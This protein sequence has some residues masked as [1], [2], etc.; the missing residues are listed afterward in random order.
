MSAT[1][2]TTSADDEYAGFEGVPEEKVRDPLEGFNRAMF[3][4]ND[5]LTTVV[6]RPL[7]KGYAY[8]VPRPVRTGVS[9]FF[10][11]VRFPVRF[12]G[13]L[14]QGKLKRSV[15]ETGKFLVNTTAG[16][17]GLIRVS[18]HVP[19]LADVPVED[20]GQT[21]GVWGIPAGPYLVIPVLGPSD[22]R[23]LVG[24]AG[25]YA[26]YP[27]NWYSVGIV[28]H[29]YLSDGVNYG[30]RATDGVNRLP[31]AVDAYDQ[32]KAD[33][34]DPYI[35]MRNGYISYRAAAVKQ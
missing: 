29:K 1:A 21:L 2:S 6:L 11:N 22:L 26:L 3:K 5:G 25:D 20:I 32:M 10:A 23:D 9:N 18:D 15:Q 16:V 24:S 33:A 8:V 7:A 30:L 4:F 17:G 27:G 28:D 13:A 14:L 19:S 34:V 35:A 31:K 12:V